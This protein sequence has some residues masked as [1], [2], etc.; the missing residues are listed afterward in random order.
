MAEGGYL[1][2]VEGMKDL[3][4]IRPFVEVRQVG[5]ALGCVDWEARGGDNQRAAAQLPR[6][7]RTL[8]ERISNPHTSFLPPSAFLPRAIPHPLLSLPLPCH[9]PTYLTIPL[10]FVS[11]SPVLSIHPLRPC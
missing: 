1:V 7:G 8:S 4:P 5:E 2:V 9:S 6:E 3:Q 10:L 11:P